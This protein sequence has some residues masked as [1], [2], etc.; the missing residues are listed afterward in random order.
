MD[1]IHPSEN[2]A[3]LSISLPK[4]RVGTDGRPVILGKVTSGRN[5]APLSLMNN[6]IIEKTSKRALEQTHNRMKRLRDKERREAELN[7]NFEFGE[8][9]YAFNT[10]SLYA[11]TNKSRFRIF[12]VRLMNHR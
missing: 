10:L 4:K 8:E 7:Y 6:L 9:R 12:C 1:K 11:F 3:R 2:E 5:Q